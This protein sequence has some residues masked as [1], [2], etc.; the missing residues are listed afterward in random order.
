MQKIDFTSHSWSIILLSVFTLIF[1]GGT[2]YA[3]K[4][5]ATPTELRTLMS[6]AFGSF[7]GALLLS[8]RGGSGSPPPSTP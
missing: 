7:S 4:C 5:G 2:I 8:L 1:L 3:Y 6:G